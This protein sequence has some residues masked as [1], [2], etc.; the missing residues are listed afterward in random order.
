MPHPGGGG[1]A[2]LTGTPR[3]PGAPVAF[4]LLAE[5][6]TGPTARVEL[7]RIREPHELAGRLVAVKRLHPHIAEDPQFS[8]M[9]A[10]EVWMTASLEH[11]NVVRVVA[12]GNDAEG[13]Y[14]AVELVEGV[15]L[16][17]LMKTVFE[18]GEAFTER[19][20]VFLGA[21]ILAGL[22]AAH[23]LRAPN[24]EHLRLVHRDLTPG[25]VLLGFDGG[26]KIADFGLAKAKQRVTKTLTGLLKGHPQYMA[27]EQAREGQLDGRADLF[28]LGVVLFELFTGQHPWAGATE[29]DVFRVML[30]EP[31]TDILS[32][33]PKLDK[34]LALVVSRLLEKDPTRR[35]QTADEVRD[36]LDMWLYSHGYKDDS[37]DSLARFVRRNAMRQMRWFERA[38][39]G[40]FV[41]ETERAKQRAATPSRARPEITGG[42]SSVGH[43]TQLTNRSAATASPGRR[44][45]RRDRDES[46][47][48]AAAPE[49]PRL[50]DA[51]W[52]E[53]QVPTVVKP[54]AMQSVLMP[55]KGR[56]PERAEP[57]LPSFDDESEH[58]PDHRTT[59]VKPKAP[60]IV[61]LPPPRIDI[62]VA[63]TSRA[64]LQ[65]GQRAL[66][67]NDTMLD[68]PMVDMETEQTEPVRRPP[69]APDSITT[70]RSDPSQ[71]PRGRGLKRTLASAAPTGVLE[72]I[73][74]A[75]PTPEVPTPPV[76]RARVPS[77]RTNFGAI[78]DVLEE[79]KRLTRAARKS[80][81]D[82][83]AAAKLAAHRAVI[84]ELASDA[85][86]LASDAYRAA[87][88]G[89]LAQ[90]V[91][92][93]AEA[94]RIEDTMLQ[95]ELA[96]P[97][98]YAPRG[99]LPPPAPAPLIAPP[100]PGPRDSHDYSASPSV[101]PPAPGF[102][103]PPQPPVP[104]A[105]G[106][107]RRVPVAEPPPR[108]G[109][110]LA[111]QVFGIPAPAAI[112]ITFSIV[113]ALVVLVAMLRE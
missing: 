9:F 1:G 4:D 63:D 52:G 12:W 87:V 48:I 42:P 56:V 44:R 86:Q 106:S 28:S 32:L 104:S 99:S 22:S 65:P 105:R 8:T 79:A 51:D 72:A 78:A 113:V 67:P 92:L 77:R 3:G 66:P 89:G 81:A 68:M 110:L 95:A 103:V 96:P 46:T 70:P 13:T 88:A 75:P 74:P 83:E 40:E 21:E 20:V 100:E 85:A 93:L 82:A 14:L 107:S 38:V 47:P 16:A 57:P 19:M 37:R 59:T 58:E 60:I 2:P 64:G 33:R 45:W 50:E 80:S 30:S 76:E 62:G 112:L 39:G 17:R 109:G 25:N 35:F 94:H 55:Q 6:A 11:P 27:P 36:R 26:V 41:R 101:P 61:P 10:D 15:S 71:E 5:V 49:P 31:P 53:E 73:P 34:E 43:G 54:H 24:G 69:P 29:L 111:A 84:S 23:A 90:A 98:T 91:P 97:G 108:K 7:C 18:T 102:G